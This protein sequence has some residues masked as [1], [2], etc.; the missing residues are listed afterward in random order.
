MEIFV[1][2]RNDMHLQLI[3]EYKTDNH[4]NYLQA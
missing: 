4:F 1:D 2:F 3:K